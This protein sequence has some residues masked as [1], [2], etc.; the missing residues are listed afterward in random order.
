MQP[1]DEAIFESSA[2]PNIDDKFSKIWID[3]SIERCEPCYQVAVQ[4]LTGGVSA[5]AQEIKF[6]GIG[7]FKIDSVIANQITI[8]VR[9]KQFD[10][11][12][13]S[14]VSMPA[15]KLTS[16]D[17]EKSVKP[18]YVPKSKEPEFGYRITFVTEDGDVKVSDW[19]ASKDLNII[20]GKK[21]IKDMCF[22]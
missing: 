8:E 16:A 10:P 19:I 4:Q 17:P 9:S 1:G 5:A 22:H 13:N 20:I 3:Y 18:L 14:E 7:C 15:I 2:I 6:Q 11:Q 12:G 21:L